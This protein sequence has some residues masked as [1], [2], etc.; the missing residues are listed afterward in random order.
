MKYRYVGKKTLQFDNANDEYYL[1]IVPGD[2]FTIA[3][4][5]KGFRLI[6]D[7]SKDIYFF[8]TTK[9]AK[10]L[11]KESETSLSIVI[12]PN[13]PPYLVFEP[14]IENVKPL[15]DYFNEKYFNG[16][17]P[18]VKVK[19]THKRGNYGLAQLNWVGRKP[20]FTLYVS[21]AVMVDRQMFCD[22]LVHEMIHLFHYAIGHTKLEVGDAEAATAH[23]HANHGPLFLQEMTRLNKMGFHIDVTAGHEFHAGESSERFYG[24]VAYVNPV[25]N[26][27]K[28]G[29]F[30][31]SPINQTHL[32]ADF[33]SK[34]TVKF[35]QYSWRVESLETNDKRFVQYTKLG[36]V[37]QV[38]DQKIQI[39]NTPSPAF[40]GRVLQS[41]DLV[42]VSAYVLPTP[43]DEPD[44]YA[45]PLD[46]FIVGISRK[47]KNVP[48]NILEQ[49]WK[50]TPL[51]LVNKYAENAI[52]SLVGRVA[53]KSIKQ[54]EVIN[55][56]EDLRRM[57][58]G[59][60]TNT[61]YEDAI[62]AFLKRYDTKGYLVE[63]SSLLPK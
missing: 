8:L 58:V 44:L 63:Y 39:E 56:I 23:I 10:A 51:R 55:E 26:V 19:K 15:Y 5:G 48:K 37:T 9:E 52:S 38:A 6:H 50:T 62:K 59:R 33:C 11:L 36:K 7:N 34:L 28:H 46:R 43:K 12:D 40:T 31:W 47:A 29:V 13:N 54:D 42:Q 45:M 53:R 2:S 4:Y 3:Q 61:Q 27:S 32:I 49:R 18:V 30:F 41:E 17:C 24:L 16:K 60:F 25:N 20:V 22:A 57:Y 14:K 21:E 35:P 1:N